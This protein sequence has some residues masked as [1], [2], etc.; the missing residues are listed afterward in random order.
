MSIKINY[1]YIIE[2]IKNSEKDI[3]ILTQEKAQKLIN[4]ELPKSVFKESY[5]RNGMNE[6]AR[7]LNQIGNYEVCEP[8]IIIRKS[9]SIGK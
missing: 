7:Y 8:K 9:M 4:Q 3:Y 1:K 5:I 6:L 2:D